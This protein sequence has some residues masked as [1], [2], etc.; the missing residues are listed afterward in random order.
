[1]QAVRSEVAIKV[2]AVVMKFSVVAILLL[3]AAHCG[4]FS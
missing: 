1:L 4:T 2:T 3:A